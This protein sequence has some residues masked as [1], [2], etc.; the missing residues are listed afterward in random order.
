MDLKNPDLNYRYILRYK[1]VKGK[2]KLE[3]LIRM[4]D[5]Y[6]ALK[7][8]LYFFGKDEKETRMII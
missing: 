2:K 8:I 3:F 1:S 7:I 4:V 5:V 6:V